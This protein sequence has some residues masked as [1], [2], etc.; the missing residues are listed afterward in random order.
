MPKQKACQVNDVS[1]DYHLSHALCASNALIKKT[2][3]EHLD[4][5]IKNLKNRLKTAIERNDT[6]AID[7]I[8]EE[9]GSLNRPV[10]IHVEYIDNMVEDGGRVVRINNQLIVSL[11]KKLVDGSRKKDG[12]LD[13][14]GVRRLR[15]LMAHELGHIVLHIDDLLDTENL[16]G[17]K[18]LSLEAED[19]ADIFA[20]ELLDLRHKRNEEYFKSGTYKNF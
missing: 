3:R 17:D 4:K 16:Q 20:K 14:D 7:K 13:P 2:A 19:E 8:H 9:I 15:K 6:V 5:E 12:S 10:L 11:P 18:L 1:S